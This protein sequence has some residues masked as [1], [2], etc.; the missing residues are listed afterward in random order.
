MELNFSD[1][2][3]YIHILM[4]TLNQNRVMKGSDEKLRKNK[5]KN[6]KKKKTFLHTKTKSV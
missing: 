5:K 2:I 6:K 1:K 3:V 4:S